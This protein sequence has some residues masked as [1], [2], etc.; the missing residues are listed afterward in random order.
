MH[1]A[2]LAMPGCFDSGL[3]TV[4]DVLR[5]AERLRP[6]VDRSIEP[7]EL[8]TVSAGG[9]VTTGGGLRL[10]PDHL[11]GDD[12]L[13]TWCDLLV[14]PGLGASSPVALAD[15]LAS[16]PVRRTRGWLAGASELPALAAACTGTFVLGE[17]GLLDGRRATTTWWL[18]GEF[19]RRYPDVELEMS[20]MVVEDGPVA[21]AGAAFAHI[22]LAIAVVSRLSP[23]LASA[24]ARVL[25]IDQRPSVGVAAAV[26]H[27]A[28]ADALVAE[29]E[30]WLRD[31]LD[32]ADVSVAAAA[33]GIGTTRR[34]LERRCR[35]ST[36]LSPHGLIS[37]LRRERAVHL[38][39]TT[40]LSHDQ[41]AP[42][43]GYRHGSTLRALLRR[44]D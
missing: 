8:R 22:D 26:G 27:L 13:L 17:A 32:G 20:R 10:D 7:I 29:F 30:E 42:L 41:I 28:T 5:T 1:V 12:D 23:G 39:L 44:A 36:G 9:R 6:E 4:L 43:V 3:A 19:A 16:V 21:T 24:V 18:A 2:V 35:A 11:V 31:N 15:S 34:T 25:L 33:A 37:R 40:E 14:V 38:R